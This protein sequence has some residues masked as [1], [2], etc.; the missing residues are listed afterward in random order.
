MGVFVCVCFT[1][2]LHQSV[3]V[4]NEIYEFQDGGKGKVVC[5]DVDVRKGDFPPEGEWLDVGVTAV[6]TQTQCGIDI[7]YSSSSSVSADEFN[8]DKDDAS[9]E[10]SSQFV[11]TSSNNKPRLLCMVTQKHTSLKKGPI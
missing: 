7:R 8:N 3:C 9:H 2:L 4:Q 5:D 1:G 6:T 10:E 11:C